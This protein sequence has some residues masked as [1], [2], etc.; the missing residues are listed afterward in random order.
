VAD[1]ITHSLSVFNF[2]FPLVGIRMSAIL[3]ISKVTEG[4]IICHLSTGIFYFL[5]L[6]F[7]AALLAI[8][9]H[10]FAIECGASLVCH[11]IESCNQMIAEYVSAID[12]YFIYFLFSFCVPILR[13][14]LHLYFGVFFSQKLVVF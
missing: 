2:N 14:F 12:P 6:V 5:F 7:F 10:L 8:C 13:L 9:I 11:F 1:W 3:R 4:R